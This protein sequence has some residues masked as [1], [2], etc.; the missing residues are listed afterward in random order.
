M[1][2]KVW[3]RATVVVLL[4]ALWTAS[5][6]DDRAVQTRRWY[7]PV[8]PAIIYFGHWDALGVAPEVR[9]LKPGDITPRRLIEALIEGPH[10][11]RLVPIL[12][13]SARLLRVERMGETVMVDFDSSVVR[14]HPGGSAGEIA[15]VYAVV[16]TL[17]EI[18]EISQVLWR[19]EGRP[20]ESLVGHLDLSQPVVRSDEVIV[21]R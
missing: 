11:E 15:T 2:M 9:W 20:V 10:D 8:S 18:P 7:E 3:R 14:E 21:T 12:P 5:A 16:N 13:R 17:T 19:I 4:C 1:I 6:L